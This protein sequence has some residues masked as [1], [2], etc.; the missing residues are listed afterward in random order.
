MDANLGHQ[1]SKV[2]FLLSGTPQKMAA[3]ECIRVP[4]N[5]LSGLTPSGVLPRIQSGD[6]E[7]NPLPKLLHLKELD[8][9]STGMSGQRSDP[10]TGISLAT[11]IVLGGE[12]GNRR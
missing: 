12:T 4:A 8:R 5:L 11:G 2:R 6:V 7:P 3:L 10:E 1:A 9:T